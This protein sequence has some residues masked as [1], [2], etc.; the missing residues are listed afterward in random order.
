ML[1]TLHGLILAT[2]GFII[3]LH[4][5]T[6]M[7]SEKHKLIE[8]IRVSFLMNNIIANKNHIAPT[9]PVRDTVFIITS[10][11]LFLMWF[12]I[13]SNICN[14]YIVIFCLFVFSKVFL[15]SIFLSVKNH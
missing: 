3:T 13:K 5:I 12:C 7:T 14:S 1:F 15:F 9:V 10:I 4:I 8:V 6:P 11:T 2:R